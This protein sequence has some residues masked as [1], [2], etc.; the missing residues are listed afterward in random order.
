MYRYQIWLYKW[1]SCTINETVY[2]FFLGIL[3]YVVVCVTG[4]LIKI[5]FSFLL[6]RNN[7]KQKLI[8]FYK[9]KLRQLK[10]N[11]LHSYISFFGQ[12]MELRCKR[13]TFLC[14]KMPNY[15][16]GYVLR[17]AFA[18]LWTFVFLIST[19]FLNIKTTFMF[20]IF[21]FLKIDSGFQTSNAMSERF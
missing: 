21:N 3:I 2:G 7:I 9:Q 10:H 15:I 5:S 11:L 18:Y 17:N 12:I 20:K 13:T 6:L 4:I 14:I 16:F 8:K 1:S 19:C